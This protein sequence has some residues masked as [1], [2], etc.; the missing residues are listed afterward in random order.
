MKE[1]EDFPGYFI[2]ESGEVI[3]T[4]YGK[5]RILKGYVVP[6]GYRTVGLSTNDK[7][8]D[9]RAHRLVAQAY[10]SNYSETLEVN[11]IDCNKLNNCV[12][13]LEMCTRLENQ[14]HAA[15]NNRYRTGKAHHNSKLTSEEVIL[16]KSLYP[17]LSQRTLAKLFGVCQRSIWHIFNLKTWRNHD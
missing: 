8:S 17:S 6:K 13:N 10:L 7:R 14:Q 12:D 4:V 9:K 2:T 3:S 1:I 5:T 11:H 15:A 16:I